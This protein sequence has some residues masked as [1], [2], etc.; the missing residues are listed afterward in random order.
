VFTIT[1]GSPL[2]PILRGRNEPI[3]PSV[4]AQRTFDDVLFPPDSFGGRRSHELELTRPRAQRVHH[5]W[6]ETEQEVQRSGSLRKTTWTI[7]LAVTAL[8]VGK[9]F[10]VLECEPSEAE[11]VFAS[12]LLR[13][14]LDRGLTDSW[15]GV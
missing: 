4:S 13:L 5:G 8:L 2:S 1:P 12:V 3:A 11:R 10:G 7:G 14:K 6:L 15:R 9:G